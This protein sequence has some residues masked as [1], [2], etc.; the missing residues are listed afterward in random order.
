MEQENTNKNG[1]DREQVREIVRDLKEIWIDGGYREEYKL[2]EEI[3]FKNPFEMLSFLK[4]N[5]STAT[6]HIAVRDFEAELMLEP[7]VSRYWSSRQGAE[8][9]MDYC[10]EGEVGKASRV[11]KTMMQGYS[12]E[13]QKESSSKKEVIKKKSV[14]ENIASTVE[15]YFHV[16]GYDQIE[17]WEDDK[18]VEI[19]HKYKEAGR[20]EPMEILVAVHEGRRDAAVYDENQV[21]DE[22]NFDSMKAYWDL[23]ELPGFIKKEYSEF[24]RSFIKRINEPSILEIAQ[25]EFIKQRRKYPVLDLLEKIVELSKK[26]ESVYQGVSKEFVQNIILD[27]DLFVLAEIVRRYEEEQKEQ[28]K[29]KSRK[30]NED[31]GF[32]YK[33]L[34]DGMFENEDYTNIEWFKSKGMGILGNIFER[35]P[36]LYMDIAKQYLTSYIE[37]KKNDDSRESLSLIVKSLFPGSKQGALKG[38]FPGKNL[39]GTFRSIFRNIY[40]VYRR[41][42]DGSYSNINKMISR[43]SEIGK[44]SEKLE[45]IEK[46]LKKSTKKLIIA[47]GPL[48]YILGKSF[49]QRALDENIEFFSNTKAWLEYWKKATKEIP[50]G[51]LFDNDYDTFNQVIDFLMESAEGYTKEY[52]YFDSI[53]LMNELGKKL[54]ELKSSDSKTVHDGLLD[55]RGETERLIIKR[56]LDMCD[57]R[58]IEI[59]TNLK[60]D[61]PSAGLKLLNEYLR[62]YGRFVENLNSTFT[63]EL[64]NGFYKISSDNWT[65][66]LVRAVKALGLNFEKDDNENY[67]LKIDTDNLV[68]RIF[69]ILASP[70]LFEWVEDDKINKNPLNDKLRT[71]FFLPSKIVVKYDSGLSSLISF[72]KEQDMVF[73][74]RYLQWYIWTKLLTGDDQSLNTVTSTWFSE[75]SALRMDVYKQEQNIKESMARTWVDMIDALRLAFENERL[76]RTGVL[77]RFLEVTNIQEIVPLM[78]VNDRYQIAMLAAS[79]MHSAFDASQR[80]RTFKGTLRLQGTLKNVFGG[81][82]VAVQLSQDEIDKIKGKL[83]DIGFEDVEEALEMFRGFWTNFWHLRGSRDR[84]QS[85]RITSD[86]IEVSNPGNNMYETKTS[87]KKDSKGEWKDEVIHAFNGGP[88][89]IEISWSQIRDIKSTEIDYIPVKDL[90]M[91]IMSG[92]ASFLNLKKRPEVIKKIED[93]GPANIKLILP[94]REEPLCEFFSISNPK[95]FWKMLKAL[96][97]LMADEEGAKNVVDLL[98][99][100]D[101]DN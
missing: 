88:D 87:K 30:K 24:R 7:E 27:Q 5:E 90:I 94:G 76:D 89:K 85:I 67:N 31:L 65:E 25:E 35:H 15:G 47:G 73:K 70:T 43:T 64:D 19:I 83:R 9:I 18:S 61:D 37:L 91:D 60:E 26:E 49:V 74:Q 86:G 36:Y 59:S 46:S 79:F 20:S 34:L 16:Y 53:R 17:N 92:V 38:I 101:I 97:D 6:M 28:R 69:G 2:D 1:I 12:I 33:D 56:A 40:N 80:A 4:E 58:P 8:R 52:N 68:E 50:M 72:D 96:A 77:K 48:S 42:K 21:V 10:N 32:K 93:E 62:R 41:E 84:R 3:T 98:K 22:E 66:E 75:D 11:I 63:L 54:E 82:S 78:D 51:K 55:E 44:R 14:L 57:K 81:E 99:M 29:Q 100:L 45:K 13:A 71:L 39:G 95:D 23:L